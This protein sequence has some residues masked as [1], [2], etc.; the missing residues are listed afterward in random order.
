MFTQQAK[1]KLK[2]QVAQVR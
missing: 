1:S 2:L